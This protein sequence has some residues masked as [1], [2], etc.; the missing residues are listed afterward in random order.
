M[1]KKVAFLADLADFSE[2][3]VKNDEKS[4]KVF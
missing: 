2:K 4:V 1:S 3:K